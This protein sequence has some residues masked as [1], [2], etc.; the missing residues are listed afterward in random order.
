MLT[1]PAHAVAALATAAALALAG[2]S[3]TAAE[4][5]TASESSFVA[6]AAQEAAFPRTVTH[7]LGDTEIPAA[8]ERIV[9]TSITITGALLAIDAPLAAS[10]AT[11]PVEGLTDENGF[12]SQ[13]A[14]VA[15]ERGVEVLYPNLEIDIEA[16][17][18]ADP[19][20]IIL[21]MTGAE[22]A[23][24]YYD[25]LAAIAPTIAVNYSNKT[26]QEVTVLAGEWTGLEAQAETVVSGFD[27]TVADAAASLA[28]PEGSTQAIVYNNLE[29][30][31]AVGKPGGP[32]ATLLS[33]LGFDIVGAD[34]ALDTAEQAR[35]DFAFIAPENL[36]Q[37]FT[38]DT[39]LLVNGSDTEKD[40]LLGAELLA[41][42]PAVVNEQVYPLGPTSFRID[43]Y[44]ALEIV[45]TI[46]G[47]FGS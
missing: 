13:W 44:S 39:I 20:L 43:Y 35:D 21:S 11:T 4:S 1:R 9:S 40:A 24:D 27:A 34:D 41:N 25:E 29:W 17:I 2:C 47:Y 33:A 36:N 46:V 12:F 22:A 8:P 31:S 38:G 26:W 7:E 42:V 10:A 30:D 19:D 15:V 16:I 3:S 37:A 18:A 14:D 6:P 5:T 28:L 23:G 32:H 45:D